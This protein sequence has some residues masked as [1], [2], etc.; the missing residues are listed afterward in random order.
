MKYDKNGLLCLAGAS[1]FFILVNPAFFGYV[2][3]FTIC[4]YVIKVFSDKV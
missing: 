1:I 4:L 3:C 2:S